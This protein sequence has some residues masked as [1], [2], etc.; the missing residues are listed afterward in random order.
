MHW[1]IPQL[2]S[3]LFGH[4]H[5]YSNGRHHRIFPESHICPPP[6]PRCIVAVASLTPVPTNLPNPRRKKKSAERILRE[7]LTGCAR[8]EGYYAISRKE[9]DAYLDLDLPEQVLL[10]MENLDSMVSGGVEG[11]GGGEGEEPSVSKYVG[12]DDV[13]CQGHGNLTRMVKAAH[14]VSG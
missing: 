8:S 4:V 3:V 1:P 13:P 6:P 12:L 11:V 5:V 14:T 7:H 2:R 10:E 9:K